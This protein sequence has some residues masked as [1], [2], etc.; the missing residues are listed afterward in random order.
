MTLRQ[1]RTQSPLLLLTCNAINLRPLCYFSTCITVTIK[2]ILS[3]SA[4]SVHS[5]ILRRSNLTGVR[6]FYI[7][8]CQT[9]LRKINKRSIGC[10]YSF[11]TRWRTVV[12]SGSGS[13]TPGGKKNWYSFNGGLC[14]LHGGSR[15]FGEGKSISPLPEFDPPDRPVCSTVAIPTTVFWL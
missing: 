6:Y 1:F 12:T 5:Y 14:G 13:F 2:C 3:L 4:C 10:L 9:A 8:S 11:D 7:F 15:H